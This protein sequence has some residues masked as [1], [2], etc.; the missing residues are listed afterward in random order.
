MNGEEQRADLAGRDGIEDLY[1]AVFV[2]VA[3]HAVDI[4]F[5]DMPGE[6]R[7]LVECGECIA[8]PAIRVAGYL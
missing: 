4:E 3:E 5:G 7:E 8:D 2:P 1:Q 6:A